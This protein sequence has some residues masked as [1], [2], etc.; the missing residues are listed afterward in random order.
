MFFHVHFQ[1]ESPES[2]PVGDEEEGLK[3][4]KKE[5]TVKVRVANA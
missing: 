2:S 4:S 1:T 5:E 3:V